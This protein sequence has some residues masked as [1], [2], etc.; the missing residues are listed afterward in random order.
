MIP[1]DDKSIFKIYQNIFEAQT[2]TNKID[3]SNII[4]DINDYD[5]S[6]MTENQGAKIW[7]N[8]QGNLHKRKGPAFIY[9]SGTKFWYINGQLHREDGPA[10]E[11]VDGDKVWYINGKKH[12]EDG[13]AIEYASGL[14]GW[15]I[16]GKYYS[17]EAKWKKAKQ[18]LGLKESNDSNDNINISN[19]IN[20]INEYEESQ[21]EVDENGD[22]TWTNKQGQL[23]RL[24]GPAADYTNGAKEW[25]VNGKRHREDGPAIKWEDGHQEWWINGKLHRKDGPAVEYGDGRK[26]WWLN[27]YLYDDETQWKAAKQQTGLKE[28]TDTNI[29]ISNIINDINDYEELTIDDYG[30]KFWHYKHGGF[31]RSNGP[32]IEWANGGKEWDFQGK[33][34][35]VDGPAVEAADGHREWWVHG[36]LH[37][38]DGPA[39]IYP[40]GDKEWWLNGERYLNKAEWK[41]AKRRNP[42]LKESTD[43]ND[44]IDIS[45]IINDI[46][47]YEES[48]MTIDIHGT[49]IW[50][51]KQGQFHRRNGPARECDCGDKSWWINGRLHREDGPAIEFANGDK[52][53]YLNAEYYPTEAEWK[54][55]KQRLGLKESTDNIDISN[56]INDINDYEEESQMTINQ[57][58][59]KRWINKQGLLH[60]KNGPAVEHA[61]GSKEWYFDGLLHCEV[62]PAIEYADG[63]KEWWL[64]GNR[65]NTET[66]WKKAKWHF[67]LK[68]STDNIDISNIIN[69]INDYEESQMEV[70][71]YGS[72]IWFN[73]AGRIHRL[74]GPAFINGKTKF[75][76]LHGIL[77]NSEAEWE[78]AKK[79]FKF[80]NNS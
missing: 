68:E 62:G 72:Q 31:H 28:S 6:Q 75:W 42:G 49:K 51:N 19:I 16:N 35:R 80:K 73:K 79:N 52:S 46:N 69:D 36:Q 44:N 32:A 45:N 58:G 43:S 34:H 65:Y 53:W 3:I 60:R 38:K 23:H 59:T 77:Y 11:Y 4:A 48:Q 66:E 24:N 67:G 1:V 63:Y 47:E 5:E 25:W 64:K 40:Y 18:H 55:A 26:E 20:D 2:T 50:T 8:R 74:S 10:V 76:Y 39:V 22:K 70:D 61:N 30:N 41:R 7:R 9:P 54:E 21:M 78:E 29:D 27:G 15:Y 37:R 71:G 57:I 12:R 14:K 56:I 13:P 33:L 17:T